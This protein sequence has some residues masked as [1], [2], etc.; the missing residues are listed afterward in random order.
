MV[1]NDGTLFLNNCTVMNNGTKN[2]LSGAVSNY[3][4]TM[5]VDNS[6]IS[7]NIGQS[8]A[9]SNIRGTATLIHSTV[10][11]NMSNG[12]FNDGGV[13]IIKDSTISHNTTTDGNGGGISNTH[14]LVLNNS[15]VE[16]NTA[17]SGGGIFTSGGIFTMGTTNVINSSIL[18]N[19]ATH[20]DG[21]GL[22]NNGGSTTLTDSVVA[23]NGT[24]AGNGGGIANSSLEHS[25]SK[26]LLVNSTISENLAAFT[27]GSGGYGGG[28][29]NRDGQAN[30]TFCTIYDNKA[31]E[32]G[33]GI[34]TFQTTPSPSSQV[35]LQTSIVARDSA[36][37]S[38]DTSGAIKSAGYNL[39]TTNA[40]T[41]ISGGTNDKDIIDPNF[42]LLTLQHNGGPTLTYAI[43]RDSPAR[44]RI[45][46]DIC[47][48]LHVSTDQRGVKRPQDVRCDIGAYQYT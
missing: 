38:P 25:R 45:P 7:G 34:D 37:M 19:T 5:T 1:T 10:S 42:Q 27:N 30:I 18:Q 23:E 12:I 36:A 13:F 20:G 46:Q 39:L 29:F 41:T 32:S 15:S 9:I 3:E 24:L 17:V 26:L 6:T 8:G 47:Q 11:Y 48:H 2:K 33:G 28:I 4:G 16:H 44:R 35:I 43:S 14:T 22:A 31:T 40:N 21:G